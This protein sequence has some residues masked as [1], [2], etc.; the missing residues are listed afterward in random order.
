MPIA[1]TTHRA[2]GM[3]C[4]AAARCD[5][6]RAVE[7]RLADESVHLVHPSDR[8]SRNP[9]VAYGSAGRVL[10]ADRPVSACHNHDV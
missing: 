1:G 2:G 3:I 6:C 4:G 10:G 9:D 7:V 5:F 8:Q